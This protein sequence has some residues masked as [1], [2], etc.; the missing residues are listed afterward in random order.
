MW[1]TE[2]VKIQASHVEDWKELIKIAKDQSQNCGSI[3]GLNLLVDIMNLFGIWCSSIF[4]TIVFLQSGL[5]LINIAPIYV[6]CCIFYMRLIARIIFA[7]RITN[8][9]KI[10][11]WVFNNDI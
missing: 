3:I 11:L 2:N 1:Q 8:E 9:V 4:Q 6:I 7:E 5:P 10:A